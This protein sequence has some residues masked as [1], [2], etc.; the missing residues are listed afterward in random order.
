MVIP[1][2]TTYIFHV[3]LSSD[4]STV[5]V[6]HPP[7]SDNV[8]RLFI[9][10]LWAGK[11]KFQHWNVGQ[12]STCGSWRDGEMSRN[13]GLLLNR[14]LASAQNVDQNQNNQHLNCHP[15]QSLTRAG[16]CR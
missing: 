6:Y 14:E 10:T 2:G 12:K 9:L 16:G 5:A 15:C 1:C 11:T 4:D 8:L 13:S 7:A 3:G